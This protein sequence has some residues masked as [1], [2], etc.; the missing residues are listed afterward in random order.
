MEEEG[1]W[2]DIELEENTYTDLIMLSLLLG[3][4]RRNEVENDE[5]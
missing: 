3:L 1:F 2:E 4:R 5:L